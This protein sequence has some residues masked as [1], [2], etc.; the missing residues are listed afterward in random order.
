MD[1]SRK[2][3]EIIPETISNPLLKERVENCLVNIDNFFNEITFLGKGYCEKLG[4]TQKNL[5]FD[6]YCIVSLIDDESKRNEEYAKISP[7]IETNKGPF[8]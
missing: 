7:F 8:R 6:M 4:K 3:I 5:L 2:L 1:Y